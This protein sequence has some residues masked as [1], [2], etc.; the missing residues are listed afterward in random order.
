MT[1]ERPPIDWLLESL[2]HYD[3][4]TFDGRL[5][6][7]YRRPSDFDRPGMCI[8]WNAR[9]ANCIAGD[10]NPRTGRWRI[11]M[12]PYRDMRRSQVVWAMAHGRWVEAPF[13]IDHIDRNKLNDALSNLREVTSKENAQNRTPRRSRYE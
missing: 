6:W 12:R 13:M 11:R 10:I 1:R 4:E 2:Y 8:P 9:F 7:H 3:D 5:C